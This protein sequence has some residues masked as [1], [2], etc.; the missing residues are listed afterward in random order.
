MPI[1]EDYNQFNGRHWE[2]GTV[3]NFL[4]YTGVKAPHT[5]RPYSEALLMGVS[6]G[7]VMGYFSFAYEGYDPICRL[8]TRN[9]FDPLDTMLA[10]LGVV[11]HRRHTSS[12]TK[13][14]ANLIDTLESGEPAIV[15]ADHFSLPYSAMP[16]DEGMW[17]MYPILVYGYDETADT[18]H[19]ADRAPIP[20]TISTEVLHTARAR[21]KK[22][23]FRILTLEPPMPDKLPS[24]VQAGIW[25][26][27]K[28]YTEKPPKGSKNNF[29]LAA[30]LHWIK[31]LTR[32]KTRLSWEKEFPAGRKMLAGL[33]GVFDSI[34]CF[35]NVGYAERDVFADFLEEASQILSKPAL[36]EVAAQ[37]RQSGEAWDA[38]GT[39]VLPDEVPILGRMRHILLQQR[40]LLHSQGSAAVEQIAQLKQE[41]K[42][43]LKQSETE[44]PLNTQEVVAFRE[45]MAAHLEKIQAIEE[46][47]VANL[48]A[49]M[50]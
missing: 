12:P 33:M 47:A 41:E 7:A 23:K 16:Y 17:G 38:F 34:N 42:A 49:A 37:F 43:L 28:L 15:W 8:L 19:I 26:C 32:P 27:I 48:K 14:V 3:A 4:A 6:G 29:G 36:D 39:A 24:A 22:D 44:F 31:L 35:G 30:Y 45:N 2:T 10:R 1:L 11:Q 5:G 50:V 9:T 25:D 18:V 46:T 20:L 21:V 40:D 13:A